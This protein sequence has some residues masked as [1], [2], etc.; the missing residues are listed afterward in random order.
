MGIGMSASVTDVLYLPMPLLWLLLL[1]LVL[2]RWQR[3]SHRLFAA[4]T[5]LF[6][7]LSLPAVGTMLTLPL[8]TAAPALDET[9]DLAGVTIMVPTAGVFDDSDGQWWATIQSTRRVVAGQL[10]Q[11]RLNLPMII[12][13][14][15]PYPDQPPEDRKSVV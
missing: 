10:L 8:K 12:A 15:G 2:W 6:L 9:V 14:G 1:A 13:G 4:T 5:L 7:V 11:K 3:L